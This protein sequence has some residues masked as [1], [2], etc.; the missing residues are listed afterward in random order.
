[1]ESG[2][3]RPKTHSSYVLGDLWPFCSWCV[4]A[5]KWSIS[6]SENICKLQCPEILLIFYFIGIINWIMTHNVELNLHHFSLPGGLPCITGVSIPTLITWSLCRAQ[7]TLRLSVKAGPIFP[8]IIN[9]NYQLWFEGP[10]MNKINTRITLKIP[11]MKKLPIRS[12]DKTQIS[13]WA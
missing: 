3:A 12:W 6:H 2:T 5:H 10:T 11:K 9:I 1:M 4:A 8:Y 13:L 7:L